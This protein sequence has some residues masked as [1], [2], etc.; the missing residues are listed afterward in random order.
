VQAAGR[1]PLDLVTLGVDALAVS[2]HK[3]GGPKGV[4]ALV[5]GEG[6]DV[7]AFVS[8][9][10]QEQGR[11]GGT[12]NVA[13]IAGFGAAARAAWRDLP[14]MDRLAGLRDLFEADVL[15]A[16]PA[17]VVVGQGGPRLATTSA[18]LSPTVKA[19]TLVIRMD[20]AGVAISAGAACSSGKVGRSATLA[21]LGFADDVAARAI[22]VSLGWTTS[23]NDIDAV[24]AAWRQI[25]G[26]A[27][28]DTTGGGAIDATQARD[29]AMGA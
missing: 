28:R 1:L 6:G 16:T 17:A 26:V 20:L 9:G 10:G 23:G 14:D 19:E 5:L 12:E 25:H 11:R 3:I 13:G 24:T 18:V 21:A 22:R 2:A 27:A 8:G 29:M 15:R 7:R 4:G